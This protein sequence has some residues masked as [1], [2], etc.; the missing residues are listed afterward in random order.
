MFF[1]KIDPPTTYGKNRLGYVR[2]L[3]T[4][5]LARD[6][7]ANSE[8]LKKSARNFGQI[9]RWTNFALFYRYKKRPKFR[10]FFP[11]K[12]TCELRWVRVGSGGPGA[13]LVT[14]EISATF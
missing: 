4:K 5:N 3:F 10:G 1:C 9:W 6:A 7:R 11:E 8:C 14:D 2:V 12:N 13:H